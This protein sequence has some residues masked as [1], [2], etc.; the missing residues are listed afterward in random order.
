MDAAGSSQ[1][2]R[3][4]VRQLASG[5]AVLA[6][7]HG[8]AAHGTTVSTVTAVS[9]DPLLIAACL[10]RGST[11][12]S[13]AKAAQRFSVN[14]LSAG[15]APLAGW[16]A[17]P[18]RPGGLAQFDCTD[19]ESDPF[20]GAP[21]LTG[22]LAQMGC[23]LTG[24]QTAGDHEILLAEVVTASSREGRPLLYFAG[25]LHDG[26]LRSLPRE[27]ITPPRRPAPGT[28]APMRATEGNLTS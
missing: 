16:F 3:R 9:R 12:A 25:C 19:W 27:E 20:S 7:W 11:V 21:F 14:L 23:R 2:C 8:D 5:V 13:L 28:P 26:M 17:D 15:Q 4:A 1:Q 10:R 22:A 6:V 18:G 24:S